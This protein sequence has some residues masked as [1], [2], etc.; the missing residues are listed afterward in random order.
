MDGMSGT[1]ETLN[2]LIAKYGAEATLAAVLETERR[3][4]ERSASA[5]LR[6][7]VCACHLCECGNDDARGCCPVHGDF[8]PGCPV[9]G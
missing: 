8:A 7:P 2:A 1:I 4:S 5:Q 6:L 3:M 9:H